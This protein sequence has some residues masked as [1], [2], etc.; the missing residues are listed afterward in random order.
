MFFQMATLPS[1]LL[2]LIP[3]YLLQLA[4]KKV[5]L[6]YVFQGGGVTRYHVKPR[7][8]TSSHTTPQRSTEHH[9]RDITSSPNSTLHVM[10]RATPRRGTRPKK[11]TKS[12]SFAPRQQTVH[13]LFD[14][15]NN[16][17]HASYHFGSPPAPSQNFK[18]STA[19]TPAQAQKKKNTDEQIEIEVHPHD[20]TSPYSGPR[21]PFCLP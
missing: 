3:S 4:A 21:P 5:L 12:H 8:I 14:L 1:L 9:A 17:Q 6:F 10:R 18:P 16:S 7:H 20:I 19:P 15:K 2:L 11:H 13:S